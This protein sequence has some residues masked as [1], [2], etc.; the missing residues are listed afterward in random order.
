MAGGIIAG[1]C[2]FYITLPIFAIIL[3][4]CAGI[5]QYIFDYFL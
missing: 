2:S 3:G 4:C 5:T 1:A